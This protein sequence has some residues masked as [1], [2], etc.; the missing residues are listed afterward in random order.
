MLIFQK[1]PWKERAREF[2]IKCEQEE[3]KRLMGLE[4]RNFERGKK[5][6]KKGG[7]R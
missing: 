3:M 5:G 7:E 6:R 4:T 2:D 1:M